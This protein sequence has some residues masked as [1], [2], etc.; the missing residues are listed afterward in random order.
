M[1]HLIVMRYTIGFLF[2]F[3]SLFSRAQ[4]STFNKTLD[5]IVVTATRTE[6]KMGNVAV[7]VSIISKKTLQQAGSL[8]LKDALQEQAGLFLTNGFGTG[9][10]MQGLNPD[11][12]LIMV[13]GEPLVGRTA[14]VLDLNRIAVGNIKKIEIVKGPSSSLY[15]SEALA[16]VINIITDKKISKSL[17]AGARY[18]FGN[19]D[20]GWAFPTGKNT[21][22]N[23]DFNITASTYLKNKTSIKFF[24]DANYL[25]AAS[26]RLYSTDRVPQPIWRL[27]NQLQ[28]SHSFS[29]KTDF[30]LSI[31]HTYDH[32]KE[33]FGTVNNGVTTTSYGNESNHDLNIIP[34][35]T[36]KPSANIKTTFKINSTYYSGSQRLK[37]K[38][39]LDSGYNDLFRQAYFRIENQTDV[40]VKNGTLTL[41][42]GIVPDA[43]WSTRY[44]NFNDHKRNTPAYAFAQHEWVPST[45]LTIYSGVRYDVNKLYASAISPKLAVRYKVNENIFLNA[46]IGRGFKPPD[47][48]Q[49]Y[50]NFT[51]NSAGAY[52]V[53]GSIDAVTV[54]N[55]WQQN[56]LIADIRPEFALLKELKPE[57]STGINVGGT[58]AFAKNIFGKINFFRNDITDLIDV[59]QVATKTNGG[60]VYSYINIKNALT[61]GAEAELTYKLLPVLSCT[62]GYQY[63]LTA[64]KDELSKIKAGNV[65]TRNASGFSTILNR[66]EYTGLPN[67]SGHMVNLKILFD[68]NMGRYATLRINW[69]SKWY[70]ADTDGNGVYNTVDQSGAAFALI[71]I[72]AGK[73]LKKLGRLYAGMDNVLNYQDIQNLPN[74]PGRMIYIGIQKKLK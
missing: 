44:D 64:D 43:V 15:G 36:Y 39:I 70:V 65:Y 50:L 35:F 9:V 48:R 52:S 13:D 61:E 59:R 31:R 27:T 62:T 69:R 51:N 2:V 49:M 11:Y 60:Q 6:R 5:E 47:F 4:D 3:L 46:S 12:T 19:P 10:Q 53:I 33:E 17:E 72:S 55:T 8:R 30:S 16:G 18:S 74:L 67:R 68:D 66:S 26:F 54:I 32:F 63:L 42:A 56:G 29:Q 25:E 23:T 24:S 7:P 45:R 38:E 40:A 41:G 21:F 22:Q 14:G 58:I 20:K 37:F 73:D 28:V 57:F 34:V 71:N 1:P